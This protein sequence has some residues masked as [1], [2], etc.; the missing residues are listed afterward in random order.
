MWIDLSS[1][2]WFESSQW[3]WDKWNYKWLYIFQWISDLIVDSV[4]D[5]A[6]ME[7]FNNWDVVIN[8][9]DDPDNKAYIITEWEV[10]VNK[11]WKE[12]AKLWKGDIFGEIALICDDKRSAQVIAAS[13]NL[14]CLVI[15]KDSLFKMVEDSNIINNILV[16]RI[17]KN[18]ED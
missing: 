4:L 1:L 9:W 7:T 11:G 14:K 15:R 17:Q 12:V 6:D 3:K 2:S 16:D 18:S 13:G 5:A 10:I 8:E